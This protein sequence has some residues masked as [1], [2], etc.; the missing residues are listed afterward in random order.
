MRIPPFALLP[1]L[2][3][4][5]WAVDP[6]TAIREFDQAVKQGSYT[7]AGQQ[8]ESA[9]EDNNYQDPALLLRGARWAGLHGDDAKMYSRY[10]LLADQLTQ[11]SEMLFEASTMLLDQATLPEVYTR[12]AEAYGSQLPEL[13]WEYGSNQLIRLITDSRVD[14]AT[15]LITGL[16]KD[17]GT[18]SK[19]ISLI[20]ERVRTLS[21]DGAFKTPAQRTVIWKVCA[22]SPLFSESVL[23][24]MYDRRK[25]DLTP[26]EIF[27]SILL[28]DQNRPILSD[29]HLRRNLVYGSRIEDDD[30]RRSAAIA[31][32]AEA[33]DYQTAETIQEWREYEL[34]IAQNPKLFLET[35]VV[36]LNTIQL[37]FE[38]LRKVYGPADNNLQNLMSDIQRHWLNKDEAAMFTFYLHWI[39]E[40]PNNLFGDFLN[41]GWDK[42]PIKA[43][44]DSYLPSLGERKY[45]LALNLMDYAN[46]TENAELLQEA[47]QNYMLWNPT[48]FD[49]N[50][51][52]AKLFDSKILNPVQKITTLKAY[53]EQVGRSKPW[54]ALMKQL[55]ANEELIA[56]EVFKAFA[57]WL[58]AQK[59]NDAL[60]KA[61]VT[62]NEPPKKPKEYNAELAAVLRG[63]LESFPA[64]LTS[65][66]REQDPLR[67]HWTAELYTSY[68][69]HVEQNKQGVVEIAGLWLPRLQE[70]SDAWYNTF[71]R[72]KELNAQDAIWPLVPD[73][74]NAV[75]LSGDTGRMD[76]NYLT[77]PPTEK[78][79]EFAPFADVYSV[80][81]GNISQRM[82]GHYRQWWSPSF[83]NQ[84]VMKMIRANTQADT[85]SWRPS[86]TREF[87]YDNASKETPF[88][89]AFHQE[90][91][92][93]LL[94]ASRREPSFLIEEEVT[95]L[96]SFFRSGHIEAGNQA[97]DRYLQI[98]S[99]R[100]PQE[101]I[102]AIS[103]LVETN[104]LSNEKVAS[105]FD[106]QLLP[107]SKQ[108]TPEQAKSLYLDRLLADWVIIG[109]RGRRFTPEQANLYYQALY[110]MVK[111]GA[112]YYQHQGHYDYVFRNQLHQALATND[113]TLFLEASGLLIDRLEREG[114]WD[115]IRQSN[116]NPILKILED[117][118]K[119]EVIYTFCDMLI[120]SMKVNKEQ[121]R[122]DLGV[123]QMA[124]ARNIEGLIGVDKSD[125]AYDLHVSAQLL[126]TGNTARAWQLTEPK[127]SLLQNQWE[128]LDPAYVVWAL[129]RMR[130]RAMYQEAL[131]FS[132]TIL[133]READL[134]AT[135]VARTYL[136]KGDTYRDLE[137]YQA[138]G[139]EYQSLTATQRF[140]DTDA[141]KEARLRQIDLMIL[142]QNYSAA[143][144]AANSLI[145]RGT[146]QEQAEGHF[147]IA[148]VAYEQGNYLEA[149]DALKET[150][151]RNSGH[152]HGRLMEGE[153]RLLLPRGLTRTEV[154][155]GNPELQ[156]IAIPGKDLTLKLQDANLSVARGGKSIPV[157]ITTV[158]GGD[159]E[160][161]DL[162]P[163]ADDPTLF[164]ATVATTLGVANPGNLRLELMGDDQVSYVID[165]EFQ[166]ANNLDYS[167]KI[168][169]IKSDATL[170]AS[171][172]KILSEKEQAEA[173]ME[174][175]L[176]PTSQSRRFEG[177]TGDTVR[178]GSPIYIQVSDA[179]R[180]ISPLTD[181]I[182][183]K[184]ETSSGDIFSAIPLTET[185]PHSGI[186]RGQIETGT[187]F[188]LVRVSDQEE[189]NDPNAVI[190][191]NKPGGW[192]SL[193][194]NSPPKWLEADI[195]NSNLISKAELDMSAPKDLKRLRVLGQLGNDT[196]LLG[197]YPAEDDKPQGGLQVAVRNGLRGTEPRQLR[198][199]VQESPDQQLQ[200]D[201]PVYERAMLSDSK[202]RNRQTTRITG[203]FWI[204]ENR[205]I[206]LTWLGEHTSHRYLFIDGENIFQ[207]R[208][209]Q[210]RIYLRAGAHQL[211][212]LCYEE[213]EKNEHLRL[214]MIT[215]EGEK[216]PLPAEWF[217]VEAHPRLAAALEA[218]GSISMTDRGV[219]VDLK[220]P[221]RLKS[222]RWVFEDFSSAGVSVSE[223]RIANEEGTLLV[224]SKNDFSSG[225]TNQRLE[226]APGDD[227]YI[228]YEDKFR[229]RDDSP[230]KT[231]NLNSSFF[232]GDISLAFEKLSIDLSGNERTRYSP[233]KRVANGDQLMLIIKDFDLDLTDN[234]DTVAVLVETTSGESLQLMARETWI[235]GN[236]TSGNEHAGTFL[237]VLRF[238]DQTGGNTIKL[239]PNDIVTVSYLD[240]ENNDPGTSI[241]RIYEVI[242][243][244]GET[245]V[246]TAFASAVEQIEDKSQEALEKLRRLEA[247]GQNVDDLT[248]RKDV[249][250]V[251][252]PEKGQETQ[253]INSLTP[254]FL[255]LQ[256][257]TM[258]KHED[259]VCKVII[260]AESENKRAAAEGR[261]PESLEVPLSLKSLLTLS[262][263]K[264]YPLYQ[265]DVPG[266]EIDFLSNGIFSGLIRLQIGSPG[267]PIDDLVNSTDRLFSDR[268]NTDNDMFRIPTL[269]VSGSDILHVAV[270]NPGGEQVLEKS[271]QLFSDP[272]I[273]LLDSSY[274]IERPAIHLGQK[275]YVAVT[276]Y[277]QD[278]SENRDRII[279]DV[280]ASSGDRHQL[281]LEE[282]LS[283]S[284]RFTSTLEP[285]YTGV[286][287]Q[288]SPLPP[289]PEN[290]QLEV[291]FG[292]SLTFTVSDERPLSGDS[293]I[294][295]DVI[296]MI[297]QG[298]DA[299]VSGFTKQF[300]DPEMAV[301]TRFLTAE[302]LFE[303]A[304]EH[305]K[306][307]QEDLAQSEIAEG[308]R[309]LEEAMRDYPDTTLVAQ[310]EYLLANL[311]Q[312]ME[313]YQEAIGRYSKVISGWPDS[314]YAARS[315][316]KKAICF[317]EMEQYEQATEEYVRLIYL[318]TESPLVADATVRLG[319]YYYDKEIYDT[320]ASIFAKFE[321]NNPEHELAPR[322][323]F[324]AGQSMYKAQKF[325]NSAELYERLI[326]GYPDDK[327]LRAE[328]MY[329]LADAQFKG[330]DTVGAYRS[331]RQL[332]WDYPE[333]KWAKIA[334]G[335]LTEEA[336]A[337]IEN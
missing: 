271:V 92:E 36:D 121:A 264:G 189:G 300:K 21:R 237:E 80:L 5:L 156:T 283:H 171:A 73:Y 287:E 228:S 56:T 288:G 136:I 4:P 130:G 115:R 270:R 129:D 28:I 70:T 95:A 44:I 335:R 97:V 243:P 123:V 210:T 141:G 63:A 249:I 126:A 328:A 286:D 25:D 74:V 181:T 195:M 85:I 34:F 118:D 58:P 238:G 37:R 260:T 256:Y 32:L 282:T 172:G 39:D 13:S 284:G 239:Q 296:G 24:E 47:T 81:G 298:G 208:A 267:D 140:Q 199:W 170:L 251:H 291:G 142:T 16:L 31:Y 93:S 125:P 71:R 160:E 86:W 112:S 38:A 196:V 293:A 295:R 41:R 304:K 336:F 214:G 18:D 163:S 120:G 159:R 280:T 72:L 206:T 220:E 27:A 183:V 46:R 323:L 117:K 314:E 297:Y 337:G 321:E 8:L 305:R 33:P 274:E 145:D 173:E 75:K 250:T 231:T 315:Q 302:A 322:A 316:L 53:V 48:D 308:K 289:T 84:Q 100:A 113:W 54:D 132:F 49:P 223:V 11:P 146:V 197:V 50:Q 230:V 89:V 57:Q 229:L 51:V 64:P 327:N 23:R 258:A 88:P 45:Q 168:L 20:Y 150:F 6:A 116:V 311:A 279:V 78:N 14:D 190:N 52:R 69:K 269:I 184:A 318:Y 148:K 162:I 313:S 40:L 110:D 176:N 2:A 226:L 66:L 180:D 217:S 278:V 7:L 19:K 259:S 12:F 147:Y 98:I 309:I 186:F 294:T 324:L 137:N 127:L 275:F 207:R 177:R 103:R 59:G 152:V 17:F 310:G 55:G 149:R 290:N 60:A 188:P 194:D 182:S 192:N 255:Q 10:K 165:P 30:K 43:Q 144:S 245:P 263:I 135:I 133:N 236:R 204:P 215:L 29:V 35:G 15:V 106:T 218:K 242:S 128:S 76:W 320:A 292:D 252:F 219:T 9:L 178:P 26:A 174:R 266:L 108:L 257:P 224:P 99:S 205:E 326:A 246:L 151:K 198:R 102:E 101:Q 212:I 143:E 265:S 202:E 42:E 201:Q 131:D 191:S 277:D 62:L 334:R 299:R 319:K 119:P 105:L 187:P 96:G 124:A 227:I 104:E 138:A 276:D 331:F 301:K 61:L 175:N 209:S 307:D 203:T 273:A 91:F 167:P 94:K 158:K 254:L 200:L 317:E 111:M 22:V 233:A 221:I 303:M 235:Y 68:W 234:A 154:L 333:S 161:L 83:R 87:L 164:G 67:Y 272:S 1:L 185:T 232:D 122:K 216:V 240:A 261:E 248:I 211:E 222:I 153:L 179:D 247:A 114:N 325:K 166:K 169:E 262:R 90:V 225:L 107:L 268:E 139:A 157:V 193:S 281:T 213:W 285:V 65:E 241:R 79:Q 312:E 134:T 109:V 3:F 332:T 244:V 330:R 306:L 82:Y 329:W 155:I 77:P 253:K